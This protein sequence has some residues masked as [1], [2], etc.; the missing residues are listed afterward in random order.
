MDQYHAYTCI[1]FIPAEAYHTDY[2]LLIPRSGCYSMVGRQG[3]GMQ[4][5]SLGRG[6][7]DVGTIGT[8]VIIQLNIMQLIKLNT[9]KYI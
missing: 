6:C 3:Y 1:K 8:I 2:I 5:V 7:T 4:E 9:V